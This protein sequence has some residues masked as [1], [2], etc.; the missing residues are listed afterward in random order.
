MYYMLE[1][2]VKVLKKYHKTFFC[3]KILLSE[4]S[5]NF[6]TIRLHLNKKL[7]LLYTHS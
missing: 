7:S 6:N 3:L 1:I 2:Y 5:D 4:K